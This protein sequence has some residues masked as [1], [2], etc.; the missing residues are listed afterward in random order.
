MTV[1][2]VAVVAAFGLAAVLAWPRLQ[3]HLHWRRHCLRLAAVHGLS[4]E[5]AQ[6]LWRVARRVAPEL[7]VVVFVRPSVLHDAMAS[8]DLSADE[9]RALR[10]RLF[11]AC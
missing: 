7:P 3:R 5:Q 10:H 4:P 9:H 1:A 6:W 11:G 2:L 8:G